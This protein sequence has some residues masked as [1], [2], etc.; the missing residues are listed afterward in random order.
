V[1]YHLDLKKYP[2]SIPKSILHF[3]E[4]GCHNPSFGLATKARAYE[5]AD[6]KWARKSHFMV[7]GVQENVRDPTL[8]NELPLW[9]LESWW[10]AKSLKGDCR[11]QNS[12]DWKVHYITGKILERRCLKRACITHLDTSYI[13]YGQK[14]GRESNCQFD[15]RPLKVKNR[16][17]FLTC[18]WHA[19]YYW[20]VLDKGYNFFSNLTSIWDLHTKLWA[21][22]VAGIPIS[23]ISGLSFESPEIKCHL[24][25]S[26][27]AR[28]KVYYKGEGGGFPQ[29]RAMVNLVNP[30]LSMAH[31]CIKSAHTTH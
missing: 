2:N 24:A 3:L 7:L 30:N 19:K 16:L 31:P 1:S 9:E 23:G 14:K 21:S 29:V 4:V 12:L 10:T 5:N 8:P 18:R 11:D 15:S 13:N 22:K 28:H 27:M 20:K 6:Q 26:P 17:N 25:V